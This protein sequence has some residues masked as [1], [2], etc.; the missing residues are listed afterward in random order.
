MASAGRILI[1]PKGAYNASVTYEMLDM[2]FHNETSWLAKKKTVGIEP[3]ETNDEYWHKVISISAENVGAI[4]NTIW[5]WVANNGDSL[6]SFIKSKL[7]E[8]YTCG[9]IQVEIP[10]GTLV[11][12]PESIKAKT[13]T[14]FMCSFQRHYYDYVRATIWGDISFYEYGAW[15]NLE[16]DS[17]AT[18]WRERTHPNGYLPQSGGTL[19][20]NLGISGG[21]GLIYAN[22]IYAIFEAKQDDRNYR[23]IKVANP[24]TSTTATNDLVRIEQAIDGTVEKYRLFGEHN[25]DLLKQMLGLS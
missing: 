23:Q 21:K 3:S 13:G 7:A 17:W 18:D 15:G 10:N 20:G 8:G 2:V 25:I 9:M 6:F 14:S 24:I 19:T 22:D 11:D 5:N 1:M 12:V 4:Q 16:D